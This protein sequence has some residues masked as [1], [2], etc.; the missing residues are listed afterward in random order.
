MLRLFQLRSQERYQQAVNLLRRAAYRQDLT[1][2]QRE[3]F[4]FELGVLLQ[5]RLAD[6][7]AACAHWQEHRSRFAVDHRRDRIAEFEEACVGLQPSD[8]E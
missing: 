2:D 8:R 6:T 7:A 4:S 1:Y 5:T 3:R